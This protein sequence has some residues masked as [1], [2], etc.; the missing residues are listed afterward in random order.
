M[1]LDKAPTLAGVPERGVSQRAWTQNDSAGRWFR[2]R[3]TGVQHE[4]P[5][6]RVV[7]DLLGST[8]LPQSAVWLRIRLKDTEHAEIEH[9][10]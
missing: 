3:P 7:W 5:P 8:E 1:E 6:N 9:G 2:A 10:V 4:V